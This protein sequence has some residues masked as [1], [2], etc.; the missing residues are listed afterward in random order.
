MPP[1]GAKWRQSDRKT[2]PARLTAG[3]V[4]VLRPVLILL[5]ARMPCTFSLSAPPSPHL[6]ASHLPFDVYMAQ[7]WPKSDPKPPAYIPSN[8][9]VAPKCK[10]SGYKFTPHLHKIYRKMN[11]FRKLFVRKSGSLEASKPRSLEAS[12]CLGGN[13]EAKSISSAFLREGGYVSPP[14]YFLLFL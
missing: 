1:K 8:P 7:N 9:K 5:L 14:F 2:T 12:R 3:P 13:R 4:G 6:Y 11:S 10:Q